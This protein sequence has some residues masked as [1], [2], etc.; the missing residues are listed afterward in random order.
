MGLLTIPAMGMLYFFKNYKSVTLKNFL[1]ANIVMVAI[2]LFIFKLLLPMTLK[3]FSA[4]EIFFVNSVGLPFNSGTIIAGFIFIGLFYYLLKFTRSKEYIKL[5]TL[6]LSILFI[7]I[8]FS[9]W[10]MLPVRA[11]A[12]TMINEN[13]PNNARELLAY[14]NR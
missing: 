2:L 3:F 8:G 4:S 5:N 14:Y 7:F 1:V 13:N 6:L 11:N 10:I 9:S 12:G